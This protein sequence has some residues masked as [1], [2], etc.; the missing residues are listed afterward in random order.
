MSSIIVVEPDMVLDILL[1]FVFVGKVVGHRMSGCCYFVPI[2]RFNSYKMP[3]EM[4]FVQFKTF[5]RYSFG[6]ERVEESGVVLDWRRI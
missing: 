2:K 1:T 5:C 6:R 4:R 3:F